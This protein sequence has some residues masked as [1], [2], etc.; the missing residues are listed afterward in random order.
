ML[1]KWF[2]PAWSVTRSLA[3]GLPSSLYATREH[4]RAHARFMTCSDW[5]NQCLAHQSTCPQAWQRA[6]V[7]P[8][9]AVAQLRR[10]RRPADVFTRHH[11]RRRERLAIKVCR[12]RA[13]G[14]DHPRR[15][16][17]DD[18]RGRDGRSR[19]QGR[20]LGARH[21][22]PPALSRRRPCTACR[23]RWGEVDQQDGRAHAAERSDSPSDR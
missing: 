23:D 3:L 22:R 15:L 16:P 8:S 17:R 12:V 5:I 21:D 10:P 14:Q 20:R 1:E 11:R 18:A 19:Q 4:I 7:C 9:K 2:C 6:Q 13:T